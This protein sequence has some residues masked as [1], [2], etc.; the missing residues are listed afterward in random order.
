MF[1]EE[2]LGVGERRILDLGDYYVVVLRCADVFVAFNNACPHL[3][4]PLF[5]CPE[6]TEGFESPMPVARS[7]TDDLGVVCRWH[8]SCFDL[9]TGAVRTWCEKL[10]DNGTSPGMEYLGD[11]SKNRTSLQIFAC[12]VQDEYV[13]VSLS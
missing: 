9:Q 13:W 12:R 4:L 11:L 1:R 8:E 6:R 7:V 10:N 2:E 3:R 5:E